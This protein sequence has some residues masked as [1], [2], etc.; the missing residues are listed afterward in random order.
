MHTVPKQKKD[1]ASQQIR[2]KKTDGHACTFEGGTI[3]IGQGPML[4]PSV[5]ETIVNALLTARGVP[6]A[7][8]CFHNCTSFVYKTDTPEAV[9]QEIPFGRCCVLITKLAECMSIYITA[10]PL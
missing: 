5:A 8:N 6:I 10:N 1:Y 7:T 2:A 3:A 9:C 4:T